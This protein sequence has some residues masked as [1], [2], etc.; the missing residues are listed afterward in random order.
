MA[1][2]SKKVFV[3]NNKRLCEIGQIRCANFHVQDGNH[4]LSFFERCSNFRLILGL[5]CCKRY[6][7]FADSDGILRAV[8]SSKLGTKVQYF[9]GSPSKHSICGGGGG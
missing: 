7:S 8:C 4:H 6:T 3:R 1:Q 9:N 5:Q 2:A